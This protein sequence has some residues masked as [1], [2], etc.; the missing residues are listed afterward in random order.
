MGRRAKPGTR[1]AVKCDF[2][3][4]PRQ[5]CRYTQYQDI[6]DYAVSFVLMRCRTDDRSR[7]RSA[8]D[9]RNKQLHGILV[10][11]CRPYSIDRAHYT[12]MSPCCLSAD[13]RRYQP[14]SLAP[15]AFVLIRFSLQG[16]ITERSCPSV[17][18]SGHPVPA[19]KCITKARTTSTLVKTFPSRV[20]F[21]F[22]SS[23]RK[24]KSQGHRCPLN[25]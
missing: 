4:L 12:S 18:L 3:A 25:Y 14:A 11:F 2:T 7:R 23:S 24:T 21:I 22:P 19:H 5:H 17:C 6:S 10:E 8:T 15:Q 20:C 9:H 16:C 13:G 1:A